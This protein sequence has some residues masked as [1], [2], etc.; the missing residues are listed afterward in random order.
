MCNAKW[1]FFIKIFSHTLDFVELFIYLFCWQ[2]QSG[3]YVP[4]SSVVLIMV[5]HCTG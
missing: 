1:I 4:K 2:K 3:L 5:G